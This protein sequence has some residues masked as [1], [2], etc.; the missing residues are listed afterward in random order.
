MAVFA[1]ALQVALIV[2]TA[3]EQRNDVVNLISLADN[4]HGLTE[5]T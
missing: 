4:A 3:L 1:Q 2:L 5:H